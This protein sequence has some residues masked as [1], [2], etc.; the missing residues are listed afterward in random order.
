M[1]ATNK[2]TRITAK[3][4]SPKSTPVIEAK[5]KKAAKAKKPRQKALGK[6]KKNIST[7]IWAYFKG[8]WVELR[9]VRWPNRKASWGLTLA[10]TL[11]S[12]F[13][14]AIV[15]LLDALFKSLFELIIT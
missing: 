11:F 15:V 9:L 2:I 7:R 8:A 12:L 13:F 10:V 5:G 1:A 6:G 4:D 14:V 3:D